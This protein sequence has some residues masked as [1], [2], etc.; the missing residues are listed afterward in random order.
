M[1]DDGPEHP[2]PALLGVNV[3]P[4]LVIDQ[5]THVTSEPA[6][7]GQKT[8][9]AAP[10]APEVLANDKQDAEHGATIPITVMSNESPGTKVSRPEFMFLVPIVDL[11]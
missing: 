9:I 1:S 2:A 8:V 5:P 3:G 10:G 4:F 7:Q 6:Q 11:G